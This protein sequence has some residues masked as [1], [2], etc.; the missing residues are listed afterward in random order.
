MGWKA[1]L[2]TSPDAL[3]ETAARLV[4][5]RLPGPARLIRELSSPPPWGS[6][7]DHIR[8]TIS[9]LYLATQGFVHRAQ[10]T[11]EEWMHLMVFTGITIRKETLKK[12]PPVVDRWQVLH[13][14]EEEVEADLRSRRTWLYGVNSRRFALL[15]DFAWK[16]AP[17]PPAL[18]VGGGWNGACFFYPGSGQQRVILGEGQH[19]ALQ[20]GTL[21]AYEHWQEAKSELA[22]KQSQAPLLAEHPIMIQGLRIRRA[23]SIPALI[24]RDERSYPVFLSDAQYRDLLIREKPEGLHLFGLF[25]DGFFHPMAVVEG[26]QLSA[27][28]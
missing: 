24:D 26:D 14:K 9:R 4:D 21:P 7:A 25:R 5:H 10:L 6:S 3:E 2:E 11:E 27:L 23:D 8:R 15:L 18:A 22:L 19:A 28:P 16:K 13:L 17:L 12:S 1:I 20:N